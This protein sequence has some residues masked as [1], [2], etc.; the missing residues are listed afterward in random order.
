MKNQAIIFYGP[1]GAGKGTQANILAKQNPTLIQFDTGSYLEKILHD[2]DNKNNKK[3]EA[4]KKL[5]DSGKLLDP[6]FVLKIINEQAKRIYKAGFGIIFSGSPRTEGEAFGIDKQPGLMKT[7]IDL[8]NKENILVLSIKIPLEES[9]R[10]NKVRLISPLLNMPVMGTTHKLKTSPFTG[11]PLVKRKALDN[12]E[13]IKERLEEYT[14]RTKP[15][16]KQIKALGIKVKEIDG[17]DL[18]YK[19]FERILK[20][21]K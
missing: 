11:E 20:A 2:P 16:E 9:L 10:R 21:L 15:I 3:L 19:V 13:V 7:L 1:P 8:Y 4:Q 5:F 12:P 18:P 14:N 6:P 17:T